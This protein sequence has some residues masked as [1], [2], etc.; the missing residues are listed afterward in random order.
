MS[1]DNKIELPEMVQ[2]I[3]RALGEH[4]GPRFSVTGNPGGTDPALIIIAD[5]W[6]ENCDFQFRVEVA[7]P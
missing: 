5:R 6:V 4:M 2:R 7:Q 3:G 1:K